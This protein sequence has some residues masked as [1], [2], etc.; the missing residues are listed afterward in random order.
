MKRIVGLGILVILVITSLVI[1]FKYVYV[2][3]G[4]EFD[5]KFINL[6]RTGIKGTPDTQKAEFRWLGL[7]TRTS[8]TRSN[9]AVEYTFDVVNDGTINAK[10]K[11]DPI[12]L[13]FDKYFKKHISYKITYKDGSEVKKG[14]MINAGETKTFIV[15]ITYKNPAELSTLDSQFYESRVLL[16]YLQDR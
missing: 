8:F 11:Y 10:L 1:V 6:E 14:D 12:Y 3:K 7:Y 9:E 4:Q 13:K 5:L 2:P 15:T 16:L